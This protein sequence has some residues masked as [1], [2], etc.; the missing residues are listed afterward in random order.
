M[1]RTTAAPTRLA[2]RARLLLPLGGAAV[3]LLAAL[4]AV[5]SARYDGLDGL[6]LRVR[7]ALAQR[8]QPAT[9]QPRFVPTPLPTPPGDRALALLLPT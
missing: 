8:R 7:V 2:G 5:G 4:L 1:A 9:E 3:L 6:V